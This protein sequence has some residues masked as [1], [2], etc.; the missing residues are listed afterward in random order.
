MRG[1]EKEAI[2]AYSTIIENDGAERNATGGLQYSKAKK[3]TSH[4]TCTFPHQAPET[5]ASE[6]AVAAAVQ[7]LA[8]GDHQAE[9]NTGA[10]EAMPHFTRNVSQMSLTDREASMQSDL[11]QT[12]KLPK[13]WPMF[14]YMGQSLLLSEKFLSTHF[15]FLVI[16]PQINIIN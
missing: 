16:I 2:E 9:R 4:G 10:K 12:P 14:K 8:K 3:G 1:G 15:K 7:E 5:G 13:L 11:S 6:T